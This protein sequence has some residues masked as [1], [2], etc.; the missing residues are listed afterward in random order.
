MPVSE[1]EKMMNKKKNNLKIIASSFIIFML[2]FTLLSVIMPKVESTSVYNAR[3][4]V[5]IEWS[6]TETGKPIIPRDEIKRLNITV[7]F[8][9]FT[10]PSFGEGVF[11]GYLATTRANPLIEL[12]IIETP[13]WC[14]AVL[15]TT[16]VATNFSRK[17]QG[18]TAILININENAPA[19]GAEGFIK[20]EARAKP[21][22]LIDEFTNVIELPFIAA[23]KPIIS[24][25]LPDVNFKKINPE[26]EAIFPIEIENRGNA[27]TRVLLEA[28]GVPEG[29]KATVTDF[30]VLDESEGSMETAYL[31]IIPP[32]DFG[33]HDNDISV[34]VKLTPV[35]AENEDEVG[36]PSYVNF[37]IESRG[38]SSSGLWSYLP[39]GLLILLI[40][41]F[42]CSMI[43]RRRQ[44]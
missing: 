9:I 12:K 23:Y 19:Y 17:A 26:S 1:E 11:Q 32:S 6:E 38:F 18:Q 33:Y 20:I 14:T 21:L 31:S 40:I 35:M 27:R 25:N 41:G 28:I 5:E 34:S 15:E 7:K 22:G 29:W 37:I 10:G 39:I 8:E 36:N 16:T 24:T 13:S 2:L 43:N 3:N 44:R 30:I 42:I 4:H